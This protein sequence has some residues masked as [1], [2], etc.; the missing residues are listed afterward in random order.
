MSVVWYLQYMPSDHLP[1]AVSVLLA[2]S[3]KSMGGG[4]SLGLFM[5]SI[6]CVFP[7]S[8]EES[9]TRVCVFG[10]LHVIAICTV[11]VLG[12]LFNCVPL[13][14]PDCVPAFD[15]AADPHARLRFELSSLPALFPRM[16]LSFDVGLHLV[17]RRG[18]TPATT[19]RVMCLKF[20]NLRHILAPLNAGGAT[21]SEVQGYMACLT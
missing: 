9:A 18:W 12:I 14:S 16:L 5:M 20:R 21:D 10:M 4:G 15:D 8:S 6:V 13:L 1:D 19:D 7:I 3:F 2:F 17:W 11:G